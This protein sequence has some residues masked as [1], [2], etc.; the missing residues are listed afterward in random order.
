MVLYV[1]EVSD[2]QPKQTFRAGFVCNCNKPNSLTSNEAFGQPVKH[3][4]LGKYNHELGG[5]LPEGI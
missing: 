2:S 3:V 1:L 5:L 4:F